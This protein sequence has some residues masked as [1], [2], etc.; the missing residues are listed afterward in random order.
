MSLSVLCAESIIDRATD[1]RREGK[2]HRNDAKSQSSRKDRIGKRAHENEGHEKKE[3]EQR[4]RN[5][6]PAIATTIATLFEE[7]SAA[8]IPC[9]TRK[10]MS[11]GKFGARPHR[12][13]LNTNSRKPPVYKSLRPIISAT[14][15]KIGKKAARVLALSQ[16]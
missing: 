7:S 13:E 10:A 1:R 14:R 4:P 12:A 8:A 6:G 11:T 16:H 9:S 2:R 15:P 5:C 3:S